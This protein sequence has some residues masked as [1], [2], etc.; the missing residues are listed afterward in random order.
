M[1]VLAHPLR[2][3]L[4]SALRL[5]GPATA[6]RLART[7]GTNSG[8]TSYH[9]RRLA[10]VGLVEDTAGGTGRERLWGAAHER[11]SWF[12]SDVAGDPDSEAAND[13]LQAE[14]LRQFQQRADAWHG[15][16]QEWPL[17]WRDAAG[18]SDYFLD[19]SPAQLAELTHELDAV[20]ERYRAE[21]PRPD[22]R[23]VFVF[24]QAYPD[25][26]GEP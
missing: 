16:K 9:L 15:A 7:L 10:E 23:R 24:L 3:R 18:M 2:S 19:L 1:T 17:P 6:T 5:D 11:H 8:A 20:V 14:G 22:A 13:W 21:P 26:G 12:S 4:L 25:V